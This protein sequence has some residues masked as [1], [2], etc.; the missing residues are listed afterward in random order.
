MPSGGVFHL[1]REECAP[2]WESVYKENFVPLEASPQSSQRMKIMAMLLKVSSE[3]F[4]ILL[5]THKLVT[6]SQ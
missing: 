2:W 1:R 4:M 6:V 3:T 5:F